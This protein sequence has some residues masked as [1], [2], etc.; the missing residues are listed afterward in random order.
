M[1]T[2][3]SGMFIMAP[4]NQFSRLLAK[5]RMAWVKAPDGGDA[6]R[7]DAIYRDI[8][9]HRNTSLHFKWAAVY[10]SYIQYT[11]LKQHWNVF[12]WVSQKI[13]TF[14]HDIINLLGMGLS[15]SGMRIST[16][17]W[18]SRLSHS[19]VQRSTGSNLH[20]TTRHDL[21]SR[22][23]DSLCL[24]GHVKQLISFSFSRG[25]LGAHIWVCLQY[26]QVERFCIIALA[27]PPEW[28]PQ[29]LNE[30]ELKVD[31][32]IQNSLRGSYLASQRCS[33]DLYV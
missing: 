29:G 2:I 25:C 15:T 24:G 31:H 18:Y 3:S 23:S 11:S 16:R 7:K 4:V 26:L 20:S 21:G 12:R 14:I 5:L 22:F 1:R 8:Q 30:S 27:K 10:N 32:H 28:F 6:K 17:V 13:K 19:L 9:K 33:W